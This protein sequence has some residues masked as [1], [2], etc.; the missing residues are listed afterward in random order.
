LYRADWVLPVSAPAVRRGAV[1][2]DGDGRI[3]A[4]GPASEIPADG[5]EVV[6]LG[7]AALLPGLVNVHAHPELTVLRGRLEGLDFPTW[8]ERLIELKYRHLSPEALRVSTALGV[9]ESIAAGVT[10]LA[11]PDDAGFLGEVMGAAGLRGRVFAEVFGPDPGRAEASL[12]RLRERLAETREWASALVDVGI[13]PHAPYTVS[14]ALF[15]LLGE[16]ALEEGLAVCIHVAESEAEE[17]FVRQGDGP[18]ARRLRARGIEVPARGV[19]PVAWLEETGILE[20]RP[21]LVHCVRI[22]EDDV[23]RIAAAGA[24]VAHCPVSNARFGH[25]VAPLVAVLEAGIPVGLGS[26]SVA[27]NDRVDLLEEAR[28]ASLVQRAGYRKA[29]LLTADRALRLATLDG[30]RALGLNGRTGSLEPGKEAD[31]MA[32]RLDAPHVTPSGDPTAAV[33]HAARGGDVCLTVVAGRVLYRDG[34]FKTLDWPKLRERAV[35]IDRS[36]ESV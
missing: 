14:D 20:T 6:E 5:A 4:V 18:F 8:I 36:L 2:V 32:V 11:A 10:C 3:E 9:A 16:Y 23:A 33:V 28:F 26:D 30:A 24:T 7:A 19:S 29:G 12:G 13:A 27:S 17:R 15:R 21:L 34:S 1:R 25:G 22:D 31:L 35:R